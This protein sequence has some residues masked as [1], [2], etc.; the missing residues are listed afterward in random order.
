MIELLYARL[1][2]NLQLHAVKQ[3]ARFVTT[4]TLASV[5]NETAIICNAAAWAAP[6]SCVDLLM[7]PLLG[8]IEEEVK[9]DGTAGSG[10]MSKVGLPTAARCVICWMTNADFVM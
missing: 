8:R 9:H 10:R 6:Q 1:P 3:L 7:K 4:S 5:T 2:A